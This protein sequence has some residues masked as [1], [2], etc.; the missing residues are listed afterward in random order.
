MFS[1]KTNAQWVEEKSHTKLDKNYTITVPYDTFTQWA[2]ENRT[3]KVVKGF[4]PGQAPLSA[5]KDDWVLTCVRTIADEIIQQEKFTQLLN[6][7]YSIQHFSLGDEIK[8]NLHIELYPEVPAID[9]ASLKLNQYVAKISDEEVKEAIKRWASVNFKPEKLET[10]RSIQLNDYV[11]VSIELTDPKG[12]K[13]R[14]NSMNIQVGKKTFLPEIEEKMLGHNLN[15][16][17]EHEFVI[18][19]GSPLIKDDSLVGKQ[20]KISFKINEIVGSKNVDIA[21]MLTIFQV[22]SEAD[23]EKK[24]RNNLEAEATKWSEHLL[25]EGL[26]KELEK[27]FFEIPMSVLHTKYRAFRNQVLTDLGFKDGGNL[28]ETVKTALNIDLEEFEKRIIFAAEAMA[29]ISFLVAHYGRTLN[30]AV[31]PVELDDEIA[32]QKQLFPE[33]LQAAVKFFEENPEAKENL[34]NNLFEHKTLV[35]LIGKCS[36]IKSEHNLEEFYTIN[37]FKFEVGS[38]QNKVEGAEKNADDA[39]AE[40]PA[41]KKTKKADAVVADA[42][43]AE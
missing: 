25:K 12:H 18:P 33:G 8:I 26:K 7:T 20:I 1:A 32:K 16:T 43:V 11:N 14:M 30:V 35:T 42:S 36:L 13:E 24:F 19:A 5:F 28:E 10:P 39:V 34:R 41:A 4:R 22:T 21:D 2:T 40:K 9:F 6:S 23:L 27:V 29:R 38:E 3:A 31:A 17:V 37:P 15:D